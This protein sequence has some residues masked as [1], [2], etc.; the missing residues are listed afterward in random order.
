MR[1]SG[2]V[3]GACNGTS[4]SRVYIPERDVLD[5]YTWLRTP[6]VYL[7]RSTPGEL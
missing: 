3:L 2:T 1:R 4:V 5:R 6:T 7:L